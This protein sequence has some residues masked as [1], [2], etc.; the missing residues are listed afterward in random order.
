MRIVSLVIAGLI[1]VA[2]LSALADPKFEYGKVEEVK[3]VEW[4]ASAQAGLILTTGNSRS[5]SL[6]ASLAA[7]RKAGDNKLSIDAGGAYARSRIFIADD[8]NM[9][10]TIGEDE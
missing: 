2:P 9:N 7:S 8:A 1:A 4:K 5:T 10:G 3:D 6:S